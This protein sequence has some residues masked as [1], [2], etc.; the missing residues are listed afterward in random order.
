MSKLAFEDS[1]LGQHFARRHRP[2][3]IWR[4]AK[5]PQ[6]RHSGAKSAIVGWQPVRP[7]I[8][9]ASA[10]P[11][12]CRFRFSRTV[13]HSQRLNPSKLRIRTLI[14]TALLQDLNPSGKEILEPELEA[15]LTRLAAE[16]ERTVDQGRSRPSGEFGGP[17]QWF[18]CEVEKGRLS[19]RPGRLLDY[20]KLPVAWTGASRLMPSG[21][22]VPPN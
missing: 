4:P 1:Q 21:P 10:L 22:P 17:R 5:G 19:A 18:R 8:W 15:K 3:G 11:W 6:N 16:T 13:Q 9:T 20:D 2:C 12:R 7:P 14:W